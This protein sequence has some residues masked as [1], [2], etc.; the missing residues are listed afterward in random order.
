[1]AA[2]PG[3]GH[4][5]LA[6]AYP[7]VCLGIIL[8][9]PGTEPGPAALRAIQLAFERGLVKDLFCADRGITQA[10]PHNLHLQLLKLGLNAMKHYNND[11]VDRQG[12]FRGMQLVGGEF[13]CPPMP[14]PLITAGATYIDSPTDKDRAHALNLIQSRKDYQTKIKK[15]GPTGDQRRQCLTLGPDATVTCYP[16]PQAS[17]S[18]VVDLDASTVRTP[19]AL[20][21][22]SR[23]KRDTPVY[24]NHLHGEEHHRPGRRVGQ[25]E[26]EITSVHPSVAGGLVRTA[27]PER[28]RQRQPQEVRPR[29]HRQS[30]ASTAARAGRTDPA[31]CRHRL[32][33]ERQSHPTVPP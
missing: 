6:G 12:E 30:P 13:Y 25:V 31:Q 28:G 1:M 11:K 26:G 21:T 29:R 10:K 24:P 33:G 5:D 27:Q 16:R 4:G 18:T 7:A 8:H 14:T 32:C 17:P 19:A 22:I 20:P 3:H 23:P 9:T 2:F 15:Y